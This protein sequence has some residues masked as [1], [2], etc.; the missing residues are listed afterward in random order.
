[1]PETEEHPEKR[2]DLLKALCILTFIG[3]GMSMLA[4]GLLF[5]TI[6][7]FKQLIKEQGT[8]S[9]L[10]SEIN[11]DFLL[12]INP[13]FFLLQSLVLLVSVIG[14]A[15]MWNLKKAGFHLYTLSQILLLILPKLFITGLPF[16]AFELLI[17]AGFVYLYA[18]S[19]SLVK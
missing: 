11:M 4:N 10:G 12:D 2:S 19:L 16:P 18:K 14:A 13:L 1:M 17:T 8:Y 5:L 9:F 15:Q 3:S 6:E 7:P